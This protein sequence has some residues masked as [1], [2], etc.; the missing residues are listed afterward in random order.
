MMHGPMK[1]EAKFYY[2]LIN[3]V[4]CTVLI[5]CARTPVA[6]CFGGQHRVVYGGVWCHVNLLTLSKSCT[7]YIVHHLQY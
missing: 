7:L 1:I 4:L 3:H 6:W 2:I 5:L